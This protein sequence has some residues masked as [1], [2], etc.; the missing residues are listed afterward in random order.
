ME[1]LSRIEQFRALS[2]NFSLIRLKPNTKRPLE[3]DW[4]KYCEINRSFEEIGFREGENAGICCGPAS[5]LLVLDLDDEQAFQTYC[6]RNGVTPP[7]TLTVRTGSG[8][9]H[10]Y[11]R[12]PENG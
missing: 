3:K 9:Q 11:Y 5:G 6:E 12:Y 8:K 4:S 10:L 1:H 7:S 2:E